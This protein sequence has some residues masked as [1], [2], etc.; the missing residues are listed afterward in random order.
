MKKYL[1]LIEIIG[2]VLLAFV[3]GKFF[4]QALN[5]YKLLGSWFINS[6]SLVIVPLI[7]STVLLSIVKTLHT[8]AL[9][10]ILA[11]TF[12]YFFAITTLIIFAFLSLPYLLKFGQPLSH[13]AGTSAVNGLATSINIWDFLSSIIPSNIFL[14]F[15]SN[16]LLPI[17]F[18]AIVFGLGLKNVASQPLKTITDFFEAIKVSLEKV[19]LVIIKFSPLGIFGILASNMSAINLGT[20]SS[21]LLYLAGLYLA[22]LVLAVVVFP[23]VSSIFKVGY[24]ATWLQI[25]DLFAIAFLSGSS[26]AVLPNLLERLKQSEENQA[27]Q[28]TTDLV[29]PLG[30]VF[31]LQGAAVYLSVTIAFLSN[32]YGIHLSFATLLTYTLFLTLVSKTI[33][34]IPSGAVVVLIAIS[35]Q[36]GLPKAGVALI[37]VV[38]F[39]ANA[40][41]S[42]LNVWGNALAVKIIEK[43][44]VKQHEKS[45]Y[46]TREL[47]VDTT[48]GKIS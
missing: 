19:I 2:A 12:I 10:P 44:G 5:F 4:P 9:G 21:L 48:S 42:A 11:K 20:L 27:D 25:K 7:F 40:G 41:R 22:Y 6:I 35:G 45:L 30:Y 28:A 31:N 36:L 1:F 14:A 33:A 32:S 29:L 46:S 3:F 24:R 13:S 38:D 16:A 23:I 26:S 47:G 39:F 17:I 37:F 8:R 43:I 34:T 15:T 18:V